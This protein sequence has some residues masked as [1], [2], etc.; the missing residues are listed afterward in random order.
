LDHYLQSLDRNYRIGQDRKVIVYRLIARNTLDE[1]KV[2]ALKQKLDFSNLVTMRSMCMLCPEI[3][4]CLKY[5]IELYDD[6]C[7]YDRAMLRDTA[8]VR[9]IP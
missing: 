5:K 4:R 8:Q 3:N 1:A 6:D 2:V 9:L 7:I